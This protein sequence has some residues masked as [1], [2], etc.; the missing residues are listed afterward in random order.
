MRAMPRAP[1]DL[2]V[3]I[4]GAGAAGL[5]AAVALAEA[6]LRVHVL[7]AR[8]RVGG[9][10]LSCA[11]PALAWPIELGPEFIHGRAP[12]TMAL[13]ERSGGVAI[14]TAGS[15][16][17]LRNGRPTPRHD[18]FEDMRRLMRR[19][20]GLQEPDLSVEEFLA[21]AAQDPSLESARTYARMM[22]EGFD[23]ADPRRASVRAIANEWSGMN[24]GQARPS[25]G[26]GALAGQLARALAAAGSP[27]QLQAIVRRIAW[28]AGAVSVMADAAAGPRQLTAR[29]ALVTLPVGV[30]QLPPDAGDA[31]QFDPPLEQKAEAL[32]G[33]APGPVIK[34]V[35][36]FR[37]AF[38]EDLHDGRYR[39]AGF[40]HAPQSAFPTIWTALPARVPLLTAWTGGPSA[41]RLA[42]RSR[43]ELTELALASAQSVFGAG[44]EVRDELAAAYAHDWLQDRHARGAYSYI[45]VGGCDAPAALAE[46]LADT[47]FFAGEAAHPG[48]SGTVE[49]ALQSGRHAARQ[50]AKQFAK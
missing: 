28:R 1:R 38:W 5:A 6:G 50:I 14:D 4:V 11:D 7:E 34:V 31:V 32:R 41:E 44:P 12:A 21:R 37:R 27:V 25:G 10:I 26:Y 8:D 16:W 49:A 22:V 39:E 2:D 9:R 15:R 33:V 30:L 47:L 36:R 43:D 48:E 24:G 29:C 42:G 45:T 20:E 3:V 13:L 23:A 19:V 35:L 46:P 40:L 18:V 17:T